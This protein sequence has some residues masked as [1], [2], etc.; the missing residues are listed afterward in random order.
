MVEAAV[1]VPA[2]LAGHALFLDIDGTLLHHA[3]S[4]DAVS[5][6]EDLV[7]RLL[8]VREAAGGALALI[9]GRSIAGI[10]ALFA[11]ARFACA[12]QHGTERRSADGQLHQHAPPA[13]G[14]REVAAR[15]RSLARARPGLLIEDKGESLALHFR[16]EPSLAGLVEHEARLAVAS[17][18]HPFE[19]LA[20]KYVFEVKPGGKDKGTAI[21]DFLAEAP[22][23]GRVPVFVGDDVTDEHGFALV[24]RRGGLSIK[25][26]PGATV[27]RCRLRDADAVATWLAG[28]DSV[29]R[30]ALPPLEAS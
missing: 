1:R 7:A 19:L 17:L 16:A 27:A 20:G 26:G 3:E 22:F 6:G 5:V 29:G 24:N 30:V 23:A 18:G 2:T 10:D 4:P 9:S 15:L 8:R 25:V 28:L 21:A 13:H 12:G 14:L 11:P